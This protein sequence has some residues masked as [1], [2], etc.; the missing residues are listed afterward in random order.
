MHRNG[1]L[2]ASGVKSDVTSP[3]ASATS[4]SYKTDVFPLPSYVYWIYS[5]F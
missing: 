4:I 5:M 2:G 1:Y 3:F